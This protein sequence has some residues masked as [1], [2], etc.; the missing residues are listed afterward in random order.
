MT[1]LPIIGM[2][3]GNSYFR[4]KEVAYL[5]K[6]GI[7]K[8]G[9]AVIM[10]ADE[11]A[12]STYLAM[13]YTF[14]KARSKAIL[15]WN[16]LKNKTALVLDSMWLD[17]SL[18]EI[19]DWSNDIANHLWYLTQFDRIKMLYHENISFSKSVQDTSKQV[20]DNS[21]KDYTIEQL[22]QATHYLLSEIAFLEFAPDYFGVDKVNYVYH[23]PWRVYEDYIAGV[24][25]GQ[26]KSHLDFILLEAPYE[27]YLSVDEQSLSRLD[28]IQQRWSINCAY[29]PYI[30]WLFGVK[31]WVFSWV[32]YDI[33]KH[34]SM[35]SDLDL[36]FIEQSG[37]GVIA[38]RINWWFVDI[39]CAPVRPTMSRRLELFFSKSII[40]S[41]IYWYMRSDSK[42]ASMSLEDL[43]QNSIVRIVVKENDIH[44]DIV[45]KYFP[46]ARIIR[47]PQLAPIGTEIEYILDNRA[48]IAFWE[49]TL[50]DQFLTERVL[51]STVLVQKW[52]GDRPVEI[53]DNCIALPRWE[54]ELKDLIDASIDSIVNN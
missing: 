40:N 9:K 41:N 26:I 19:I 45:Q 50:V 8:Y 36:N 15:K 52:W 46:Q 30:P 6:E 31:E 4:N 25:D 2:S 29:V 14:S 13:W 18:I 49:D 34:V 37:Y 21:G 51:D 39:F 24:F 42:H 54:F 43:Q 17:S 44:H 47:L 38:S 10:V 32:F 48:D 5:L 1:S 3:P 16:N 12:I 23:K 11:P 27:T 20:L 7:R 22:D 28:I 33:M 35:S 53:Y